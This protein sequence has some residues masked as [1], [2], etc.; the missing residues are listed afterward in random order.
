MRDVACMESS[1]PKEPITDDRTQTR[2]WPGSETRANERKGAEA[3]AESGTGLRCE[4]RPAYRRPGETNDDRA[5]GDVEGTHRGGRDARRPARIHRPSRDDGHRPPRGGPK[6]PWK[7]ILG[8][9]GRRPHARGLADPKAPRLRP[10]R[11]N[12]DRA[13]APHGLLGFRRPGPGGLRLGRLDPLPA[14]FD[15]SRALMRRVAGELVWPDDRAAG[16]PVWRRRAEAVRR[17]DGRDRLSCSKSER[18]AQRHRGSGDDCAKAIPADHQ[19][20]FL[21]GCRRSP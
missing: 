16:A 17:D 15:L 6:P 2:E 18:R 13:P 14:P 7:I 11:T 21:R 9:S 4:V 1:Q 19:A 5:R 8:V 3:G 10:V 12:V 20:A